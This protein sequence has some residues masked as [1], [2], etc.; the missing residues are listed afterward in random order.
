MS[1]QLA[2]RPTGSGP[3]GKNTA[4]IGERGEGL[5]GSPLGQVRS[6]LLGQARS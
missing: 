6:Q 1:P 4:L 5:E 3:S 2:R